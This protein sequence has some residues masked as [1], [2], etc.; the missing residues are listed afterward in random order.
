MKTTKAF[1]LRNAL[2]STAIL[3][4]SCTGAEPASQSTGDF[5]PDSV[6][7]FEKEASAVELGSGFQKQLIERLKAKIIGIAKA[8]QTRT[9]NLAAVEAELRPLISLLVRIA[10]PRT[11]AESAALLVGPWYSLWTDQSFGPQPPNLSRIFQV[12]SSSGHYYNLSE[13]VIPGMPPVI[14]A[15]R[16]AYA[17]IPGAFAIRFTKNGFTPGVLAGKSSA[18]VA[19]LAASIEAGTTPLIQVPGPIG[20]GG[21][22]GTVYVDETLRIS[23][24]DQT[25]VFDDNGVVSVPG[26]F[27]LLFVLE[28]LQ[29]VTP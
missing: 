19:A 2:F 17:Q 11:D 3:T 24:G 13:T 22:L 1:C 8:N 23:S 26:Q 9:D 28:R 15:L 12:I 7:A 20:I 29:G 10:P 16:G 4:L 27:G 18:E 25:P 14:G 5:A 21:R 6:A